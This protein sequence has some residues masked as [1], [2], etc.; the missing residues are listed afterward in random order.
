MI[1]KIVLLV[2]AIMLIVFGASMAYANFID[3]MASGIEDPNSGIKTS[4]NPGGI[5]DALI[6]GYY[7]VRGNINLFNIVNTD[8]TNGVKVRI[9]FRNAHDSR[10]VLD[11]NICLSENDVWTAALYDDGG[12]AHIVA[13]DS[14]TPTG[15]SFPFVGYAF[16]SGT[17]KDGTTVTPDMTKEGYFEVVGMSSIPSFHKGCVR[18][19]GPWCITTAAEC[20]GWQPEGSFYDAHNVL[21]GQN[22]IFDLSSWLSFAYN[23]TSF[24]DASDQA[25]D[26]SAAQEMSV[27]QA[28]GTQIGGNS[29]LGCDEMDFILT[30]SAVIT[31]YDVIAGFGETALILTFPNRYV[32]HDDSVGGLFE[33]QGPVS[34]TNAH[35][36]AYC[37]T[38]AQHVFDWTEQELT[39]GAVSPS[40]G[41]CLVNE[42]NVI[43]FKNSKIFDSKV[44]VSIDSYDLGWASIDMTQASHATAYTLF[45]T[46]VTAS[47]LPVLG[48]TAQ[49]Y[50][51]GAH[52]MTP[53]MYKTSLIAP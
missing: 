18:T 21:L 44:E 24:A 3:G 36:G 25:F 23:A 27:A 1:R 43:N 13:L 10:E 16:I 34:S 46:Q 26:I 12:Q 38:I 39:G 28:M 47:G 9:V 22:T 33:C 32:C 14:D 45:G 15:A 51:V 6:Y 4:V 52:N 2:A 7:N 17:T 29:I 19:D 49:T 20:N 37:T 50:D 35:C 5:G 30:K 11:F 41:H 53:A 8:D 42:V 48:L 40:P 31:P